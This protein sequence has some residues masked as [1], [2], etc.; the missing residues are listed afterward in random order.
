MLIVGKC[1]KKLDSLTE[2]NDKLTDA[3]KRCRELNDWA[4]PSSS[5][6]KEICTSEVLTPENRVKEILILQEEAH[7][8]I[9]LMEPLSAD[10]KTLLTGISKIEKDTHLKCEN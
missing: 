3:V 2:Y 9:P 7:A 4:G 8:R 10:Y 6:L 5:K 1:Q